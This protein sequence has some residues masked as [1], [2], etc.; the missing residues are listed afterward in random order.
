MRTRYREHPRFNARDIDDV[1]IQRLRVGC[2]ERYRRM[3]RV[4]ALANYILTRASGE[5]DA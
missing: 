4:M 2:V 3:A 1:S 5:D